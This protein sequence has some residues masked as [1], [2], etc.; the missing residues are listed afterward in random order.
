[1][2]VEDQ[3]VKINAPRI[4][5]GYIMWEEYGQTVRITFSL[6]DSLASPPHKGRD[7]FATALLSALVVCFLLLLTGVEVADD[8]HSRNLTS[9]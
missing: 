7:V 5:E 4:H 3:T 6:I 9:V 1:M 8:S 2:L